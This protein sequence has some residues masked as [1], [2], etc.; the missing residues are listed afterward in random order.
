MTIRVLR[1]G[2]LT[3]VQDL[4][5]PGLQ[6]QAIVPGGVMDT[7]SH[8]LANALVGN[9][10]GC[11][12]LEI[13]LAGPELAFAQ[14]TLIALHGARFE[15]RLDGVAMPVSRPVL[16]PAGARLSI[17]S[18]IE[19]AFGYLAI[20]GGIDVPVVLGSRSTYLAAA[21]GGLAGKPLAAG[22][23]LPLVPGAAA[24]A[25]ARFARVVRSATATIV[26]GSQA[27]SV[28]WFAPLLTLPATHPLVLRVVDGVHAALFDETSRQAFFGERWQV[29]GESN[30]MGYRL[31][32]PRL[33]LA[34]QREIAS[35][36]VCFGTVQVPSSGQPIVLMA[37]RQT[38]GGYP[39]IAEV[40]AADLPRLAQASPGKEALRF[41]RATL[42]TADAARGALAK[43]VADVIERLRWEYRDEHD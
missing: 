18:A 3:T 27:K 1:A 5:R 33:A 22:A 2:V 28:R 38:T 37:D 32:G 14:N 35:Q 42:D 20:A 15:P 40:I 6:H 11:A 24:L 16:V 9:N 21:F 26:G 23:Q 43:R 10:D 4:G 29:T 30:R 17:G 39:R 41:E 36:S 34:A 13:A 12:T 8:R 7:V 19:G 31:S 25:V